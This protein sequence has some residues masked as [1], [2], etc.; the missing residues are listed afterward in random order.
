[1]RDKKSF[2]RFIASTVFF[3][4]GRG[5]KSVYKLD[6]NAKSELDSFSDKQIIRFKIEPQGPFF[7]FYKEEN[8]IY[9]LRGSKAKNITPYIDIAFKNIEGALLVLTGRLGIEQAYVQHRFILYGDIYST[10]A[11]VRIMSMVE[12]YLFPSFMTNKILIGKPI[13]K[14]SSLRV[15]LKVLS[16]I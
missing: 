3:F 6:I 16:G 5:I 1:M 8:K 4:L 13:K 11:V 2:K 7:A 14:V 15:Y 10:I 12:N 9:T